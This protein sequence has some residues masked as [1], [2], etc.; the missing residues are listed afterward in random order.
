MKRTIIHALDGYCHNAWQY[1]STRILGT[2]PSKAIWK[3]RSSH[4]FNWR[5]YFSDFSF[6][7]IRLLLNFV[8]K[9]DHTIANSSIF[10]KSHGD[11]WVVWLV[12]LLAPLQVFRCGFYEHRFY[13]R[14][15]HFYWWCWPFMLVIVFLQNV[16][17]IF[18]N[19]SVG[20]ST[21]NWKTGKT[22]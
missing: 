18:S 13:Q 22:W 19:F 4:Q 9:I 6:I 15:F 16:K 7:F 2:H 5:N 3:Q 17:L 20:K 11:F 14:L 12:L 21:G 10:Q 8:E 1:V